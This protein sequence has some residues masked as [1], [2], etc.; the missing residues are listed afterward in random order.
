[1]K[2]ILLV[3]DSIR[4]TYDKSVKASLDGIANVYFPDYNCKMASFVLRYVTSFRK[5]IP[6]GEKVDLIHW[7]AGL[8]DTL[9]VMGDDPHTPV[10]FYAYYIDKICSRMKKVFPDAKVIFATSTSVVTERMS[11]N[12]RRY[13]ADIEK[14]NAVAVEI[15]KKHGFEVNDLYAF[16][17]TLPEEA[18]SDAVHYYTPIGTEAF[19]KHMLK[20]LCDALDINE[21]I[22]YSEDMYTDEPE[23]I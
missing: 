22:T 23:G 17:R 1:M 8:W 3:G 10:E 19:S 15:V 6:E 21:N 18:H 14:Y 12:F 2:N 9:C 11:Q 5:L 13:N 16:S 4:S 20:V 7:N